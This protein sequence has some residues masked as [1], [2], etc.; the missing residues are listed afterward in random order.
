MG[1]PPEVW[2]SLFWKYLYQWSYRMDHQP[3]QTSGSEMKEHLL[4]FAALLPCPSC[5]FEFIRRLDSHPLQSSNH[6]LSWMIQMQNDITT[7]KHL[8]S[9]IIIEKD[10]LK[11]W[12]DEFEV[13]FLQVAT[14]LIYAMNDQK[15]L[16]NWKTWIE[17][18][19]S[20]PFCQSLPIIQRFSSYTHTHPPTFPI[21]QY[22]GWLKWWSLV[23]SASFSKPITEPQ[24]HFWFEHLFYK[25][26]EKWSQREQQNATYN[27]EKFQ[28]SIGYFNLQQLRRKYG[29]FTALQAPKCFDFETDRSSDVPVL[30][31]IGIVF[32]MLVLIAFLLVCVKYFKAT[33]LTCR[34]S[35]TIRQQH[36]H[37]H[38]H[39]H[40]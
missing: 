31:T 12:K 27:D 23:I 1:F 7:S 9:A 25:Q 33:C 13:A 2:G 18:T 15:E 24:L 35:S 21:Q 22:Q 40:Q 8:S 32:G 20:L 4:R 30:L 29:P 37:Q 16:S 14:F 19:C 39:Q 26:L 36:Q 5:R 10:V 17:D 34:P 6:C 3:I 28:K 11:N 38:Q